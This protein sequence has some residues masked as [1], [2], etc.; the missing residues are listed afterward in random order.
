MAEPVMYQDEF[1][2]VLT[3]HEPSDVSGRTLV[4][5]D[6]D[7]RDL[8]GVVFG[9]SQDSGTRLV[10][11]S[12]RG[13][14]FDNCAFTGCEVVGAAF[15]GATFASCDLRYSS[16]SGTSLKDVEI[17]DCDLYRAGLGSDVDLSRAT[18]QRSSLNLL[19]IEGAHLERESL[20]TPLLQEDE[21]EYERF[22]NRIERSD[23]MSRETVTRALTHRHAEAGRIWRNLSSHWVG[24]GRHRDAS[25]AYLA[26][27][28]NETQ[29]AAP[30]RTWRSDADL[31]VMPRLW[32]ALRA[33]PLWL[34]G[35]AA[36][37]TCGYGERPLRVAVSWLVTV[38]ALALSMQIVEGF[39]LNEQPVEEYDDALLL[40]ARVMTASAPDGV[41]ITAT[42]Q[43][44]VVAATAIGV[45]LLGL[46]G[47]VLG[48]RIRS[49]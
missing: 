39:Q 31:A 23:A 22:L 43:W 13:A 4:D 20:V 49:A 28:R 1:D 7:G 11:L 37:L 12:A 33:S 26:A 42:A 17:D 21:S 14:T 16:W 25:W 32:N 41:A 6:V 45:T 10:R 44:F 36:S 2:Q 24:R 46:M 8:R 47:F 34:G 29:A 27:K 9:D 38:V 3:S 48:N 19:N 35:V 5:V 40:S 15:Q 30:W 18:I